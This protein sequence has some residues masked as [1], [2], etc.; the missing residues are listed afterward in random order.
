VQQNGNAI[1]KVATVAKNMH[2]AIYILLA[3]NFMAIRS[4]AVP[5]VLLGLAL[6]HMS[7]K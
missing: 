5:G 4:L 2:R 6:V 1:T 3:K 7:A